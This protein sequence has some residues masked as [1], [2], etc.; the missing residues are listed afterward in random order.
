MDT[1]R[2]NIADE[3]KFKEYFD[4]EN[5]SDLEIKDKFDM[6]D[7]YFTTP[8][9]TKAYNDWRKARKAQDPK[10]LDSKAQ[11]SKASEG[12]T[13]AAAAAAGNAK[14]VDDEPHALH[15]YREQLRTA[16]FKNVNR[17]SVYVL[18]LVHFLSR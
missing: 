8:A 11:D 1:D 3:Q 12:T 6:Y 15:I 4:L 10:V 2:P 5:D 17:V 18:C 7:Q 9:K 16:D 14:R 13:A